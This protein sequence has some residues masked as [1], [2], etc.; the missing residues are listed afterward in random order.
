M[1]LRGLVFLLSLIPGS[2]R[3]SI[4]IDD[5][6]HGAEQQNNT[7][8]NAFEESAESREALIPGGS[9]PG[10]L[11][12]AG[13]RT[14]GRR[15]G[16]LQLRSGPDA[17]TLSPQMASVATPVRVMPGAGRRPPWANKEA[18]KEDFMASDPSKA[19]LSGLRECPRT[20]WDA[21][22]ES[23]EQ[24]QEEARA[25]VNARGEFPLEINATEQDNAKGLNYFSEN[26]E[27]ILAGMKKHGAVWLR[28]FHQTKDIAGFREFWEELGLLPCLDPIHS[29]GL[30]KFASERDA[31]YEEVNKPALAK[32]YIGLHEESSERRSPAA[33]AFVCFKR[34][35]GSGGR[36]IVADGAEVLANMKTDAIR[37][38][39][40][41]GVRISV[42]NINTP[43]KSKE[44][45]SKVVREGL[46]D[47]VASQVAPKFD[48]DLDMIYEA[49]GTPGRLQAV[50]KVEFP[51]N[52]HPET[53]VPAW[54][55]NA[56]NHLRY[57]RDRRPCGVPEVGM[58]D[59]FLGEKMDPVPPEVCDEVKRAAED[60]IVAL[61]ME[62]GDVLLI[63]NY[64]A[65]HGRET[66][67]GDRYHAVSWF[68]WD[69]PE[70][71]EGAQES[72]AEKDGLNKLMNKYL[73]ILPKDF[74]SS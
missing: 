11:H 44:G 45:I 72:T 53:G 73:D 58:T 37:R 64:R 18:P 19:D 3:R 33:A 22:F 12:R 20:R 69:N 7:H 13:P 35:T 16:H 42:S 62:P 36:F 38:M 28:G 67:D 23:V 14:G 52:R 39:Y 41:N 60:A 71:R 32:H 74:A 34:A 59:V 24:A 65:L 25:A 50:E 47:V 66:F 2:A 10:L 43:F 30:R 40:E 5:S 51:I 6:L 46:K 63:D 49:D 15:A 68:T 26:R 29:S 57:L 21:E 8:A 27:R 9:G 17:R 4:R 31:V 48:M 54:F 61:P 56:H 55:C 1:H 70:W